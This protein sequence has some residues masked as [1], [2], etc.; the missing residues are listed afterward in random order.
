M[1]RHEQ[2]GSA[3]RDFSPPSACFGVVE[4]AVEHGIGTTSNKAVDRTSVDGSRAPIIIPRAKSTLVG[5]VMGSKSDYQAPSGGRE[6]SAR[7]RDSA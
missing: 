5:A 6:G 7:T 2:N 3:P 4:V 1:E